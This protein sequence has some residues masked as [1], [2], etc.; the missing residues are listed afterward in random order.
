L[1]KLFETYAAL[2]DHGLVEGLFR[3][4]RW[5]RSCRCARRNV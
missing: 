1:F 4:C 3:G 2:H 5:R